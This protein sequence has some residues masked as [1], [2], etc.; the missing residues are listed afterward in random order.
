M[1]EPPSGVVVPDTRLHPVQL[2]VETVNALRRAIPFLVVT[3][4]GGAPWWVNVTLSVLVLGVALA[5]WHVKKY[6]VV[7][8]VV[9]LRSGLINRSVR[10]VPLTRITALEASQSLNQHLFGVWRLDVRSP[11]DRNRAALSLACLSGRRLDELRAALGSVGRTTTSVAPRS[12][13]GPSPIR[14]YLAWRHTTVASVPANGEQVIATLTTVEMLV[15]AVSDYMVPLIFLAALVV[16][17]RFSE[18]VPVAAA[19]FMERTIA[20]QGLLAVVITLLVAAVAA[21]V[22]LRTLRLHRFTLVRD[23]DVLRTSR[24]LWGTQ[25]ATIPLNRVQAIRL[26]EGLP[27]VLLGYCI[28]Q[29]EVAGIGRTHVR[30]R[31]LFPLV[32][33]DDAATL[34]RRAVPDLPWPS[35]PLLVLPTRVHRRYLTLPLAYATGC[36]V[37]MLFLPGWWALLAVVPLPLGYALGIARAREARWRVDD[38]SVVFRWRR[39]LSRHTVVAHRGG[40]HLAELSSS[41][42]KVKK[43]VAGFTMRFSSGRSAGIRYMADADALLLLHAVGRGFPRSTDAGDQLSMPPDHVHD[44]GFGGTAHLPDDVDSRPRGA[45]GRPARHR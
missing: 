12:R 11:A 8:G 7:G 27:R 25:S 14:R 35:D 44:I 30:Q 10:V 32:R 2:M 31:M 24:G 13:P 4:F 39:L 20:P 21:G 43:G 18:V 15:A 33:T 45:G 1:S 34:V 6:S 37:L 29:V 16:W 41:R 28:L 42:S 40:A 5:Q 38:R 9:L 17:F 36:T 3:I 26:V 22:V 19:D 23:G